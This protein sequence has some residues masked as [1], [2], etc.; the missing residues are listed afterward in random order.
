M[1]WIIAISAGLLV[2]YIHMKL[3]MTEN[4]FKDD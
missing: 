3:D 1:G 4:Y 2:G